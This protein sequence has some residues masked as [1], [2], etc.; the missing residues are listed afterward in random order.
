MSFSIKNAF[1][2]D[3]CAA[4]SRSAATTE[5]FVAAYGRQI[6]PVPGEAFTAKAALCAK[7][8]RSR[9]FLPK[10]PR[11]AHYLRRS[12]WKDKVGQIFGGVTDYLVYL[13]R[14]AS[15]PSTEFQSDDWRYV[16]RA[17]G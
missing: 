17:F 14:L 4:T 15:R 6:M 11:Q 13:A 7:Y 3:N 9:G 8:M 1:V 2:T 10:S 16:T 12:S 5:V